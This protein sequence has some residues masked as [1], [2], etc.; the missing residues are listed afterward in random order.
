MFV[1]TALYSLAVPASFSFQTGSLRFSCCDQSFEKAELQSYLAGTFF[2]SLWALY[3]PM[4]TT[5]QAL[6]SDLFQYFQ[7]ESA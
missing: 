6:F 1:R 3:K 4:V 2:E 7:P 5:G